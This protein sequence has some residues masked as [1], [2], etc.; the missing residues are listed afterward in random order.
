MPSKE[1]NTS[2]R[3]L[4]GRPLILLVF[5]ILLIIAVAFAAVRIVIWRG[6]GENARILTL[7]NPWNGLTESGYTVHL[8]DAED[9]FQ[10]D[11]ACASAL[12]TMLADCRAAGL[13]PKIA[14]AYRS[15]DEQLELYDG[16]IQRRIDAGMTPEEATE[17]VSREIAVP[18]RSEHELGLAVDLVDSAYPVMDT[19][20]G[21]TPVQQWLM[22]NAWQYGF[23]LRYP[24]GGEEMTGFVYQPWHYRYVGE[25]TASRIHSLSITLEEYLSLFYN[26]EAT[27]VF[28]Q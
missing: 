26:E 17:A 1:N 5:L 18:G 22:S 16:E 25:E 24:S 12:K 28:E 3:R 9:G 6:R 2:S 27:V 8:T 21:G 7:V 14:A 19:A 13:E 4:N 23:I 20:Q 10:V 11:K 15:N